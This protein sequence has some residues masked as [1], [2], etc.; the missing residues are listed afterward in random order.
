MNVK[1]VLNGA[2]LLVGITGIFFKM[3]WWRG[4]DLLMLVGFSLLLISAVVFTVGENKAAGTPPAL[5]YVMVVTLAVGILGLTFK[6]MNWRGAFVLSTGT[7]LLLLVLSIMLLTS[8]AVTASRQF[9]TVFVIWFALVASILNTSYGRRNA[10]ARATAAV[11]A[12]AE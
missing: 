2:S 12:P 5:N 3:Q 11:V 4:A 10:E 6:A 8:K 9:I 7:G 1:N